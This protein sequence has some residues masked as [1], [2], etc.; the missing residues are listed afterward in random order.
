MTTTNTEFFTRKQ[1]AELFQI[2]I[3]TVL[4][5]EKSGKLKAL[6]LGSGSVRYRV[7]DVEAFI[8]NGAERSDDV[9]IHV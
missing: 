3:P 1:I 8:T 4:R 7:S 9:I 6:R 2:A 5:W